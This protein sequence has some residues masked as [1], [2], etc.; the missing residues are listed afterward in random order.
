MEPPRTAALFRHERPHLT[1]YVDNVLGGAIRG[2]SRRIVVRAPVKSGKREIV[3]YITITMDDR[4]HYFLSAFHRIADEEQREELIGYEIK[5]FSGIDDKQVE[6]MEESITCDLNNEKLIMVHLDECDYG[7]GAGQ[8]MSKIWEMI[9]DNPAITIILYTATPSEIHIGYKEDNVIQSLS[10]I[11]VTSIKT[12]FVPYEPPD[13]FCGP[14]T[15]LDRGLVREAT[16]FY[17]GNRL[18]P[19]GKD[20]FNAFLENINT[21]PNR[22]VLVV[23]MCGGRD[24]DRKPIN[25]FIKNLD[26]MEELWLPGNQ[27]MI[28]R[29]PNCGK[30]FRNNYRHF[31]LYFEDIHWSNMDWW[32]DSIISGRPILIVLDQTSTR[33]TEWSCHD[34]VYAYHDYRKTINFSTISQA[35]ERVNHYY[36]PSGGKYT[37]FQPI[38]VY[39]SVKVWKLSAG[40]ITYSEF[41]NSEWNSR[42]ITNSNPPVYKIFSVSDTNA[43]HPDYDGNYSKREAEEILESLGC[44]SKKTILSSRVN[45]NVVDIPKMVTYFYECNQANF[46]RIVRSTFP[47][48]TFRNPFS[49]PNALPGEDGMWKGNLRGWSVLDYSEVVDSRWGMMVS[50]RRRATICYKDG[51][52][53]VCFRMLTDEMVPES[54]L[55]VIESMYIGA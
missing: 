37:E 4:S 14:K 13:A 50:T 15:F 5:V 41:L 43:R 31:S 16:P 29:A 6:R 25:N 49:V 27:K 44:G 47:D 48:M 19:Q 36:S 51:T 28:V 22:N 34:R 33:S 39:G 9:S 52:L 1:H 54:N 3:E 20:I 46:D 32:N 45:G 2:G 23:R 38:K 18:T 21:N 11:I 42:K 10:A 24:S 30:K 55:K 8:N 40:I 12:V 26:K 17:D 7:S 53:G 35:Q